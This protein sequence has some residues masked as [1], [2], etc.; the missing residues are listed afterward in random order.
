MDQVGL[1]DRAKS[2]VTNLSGGESQR[3]SLA[4]AIANSPTVLL[5]DKPTSA[6]DEEAKAEVFP[7]IIIFFMAVS[8]R[9][10]LG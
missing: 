2:D 1:A 5:M 4:R 9:M 7:Y 6:L 8:M 10:P 3:V